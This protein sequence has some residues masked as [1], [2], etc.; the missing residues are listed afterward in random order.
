[1]DKPLIH[2]DLAT[3]K[4]PLTGLSEFDLNLRLLGPGAE[5]QVWLMT[6]GSLMEIAVGHLLR[7][8]MTQRAVVGPPDRYSLT[9]ERH[10]V[11]FAF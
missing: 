9:I 10:S 2:Q 7:D 1:L 4:A 3:F 6:R 5:Q 11:A 8:W